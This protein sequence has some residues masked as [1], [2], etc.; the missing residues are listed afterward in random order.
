MDLLAVHRTF[1]N[2]LQHHNLKSISSLV[3][4]LLYGPALHPYM[5]TGKT[6]SLTGWIYVG[7][8]YTVYVCNNFSS[9]EQ[10]WLSV[11]TSKINCASSTQWNTLKL[12]KRMK[13]IVALGGEIDSRRRR[14]KGDIFHWMSFSL[15]CIYYLLE[16]NIIIYIKMHLGKWGKEWKA[17]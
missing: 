15:F 16:M 7:K 17:S 4:S 14:R 8:K 1:K 5:T 6:I 12:L 10:V 9:K 13:E 2:L 3:L 11:G